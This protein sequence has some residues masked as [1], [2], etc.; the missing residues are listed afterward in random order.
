MHCDGG[1]VFYDYFL[2]LSLE[3]QNIWQKPFRFPTLIFLL[4]RY[5]CIALSI[6]LVCPDDTREVTIAFRSYSGLF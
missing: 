6:A 5:L 2:T 3:I 1:L 4:N